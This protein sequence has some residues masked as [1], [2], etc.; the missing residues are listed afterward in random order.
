MRCGCGTLWLR[1]SMA[2][3]V[4][5]GRDERVAHELRLA[6]LGAVTRAHARRGLVADR[7]PVALGV[8]D[9]VEARDAEDHTSLVRGRVRVRVRVRR[10][11]GLRSSFWSG[12]RRLLRTIPKVQKHARPI[13]ATCAR[14]T[15]GSG[16]GGGVLPRL[17]PPGEP[18]SELTRRPSSEASE[19][20]P[21]RS[22]RPDDERGS[23]SH[24]TGGASLR[25]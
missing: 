10:G 23:L 8:E 21:L 11:P 19:S 7:A 20:S 12:L 1:H 25:V 17:E 2:L 6:A 14:D 13:T 22:R 3:R 16:G 5:T 4:N 18:D 15:G 9:G 24:A